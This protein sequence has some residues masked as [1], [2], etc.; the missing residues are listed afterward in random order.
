MSYVVTVGGNVTEI[1]AKMK[2]NLVMNE[3]VQS[4]I[5]ILCGSDI[6]EGGEAEAGL[7]LHG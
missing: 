5:P 1:E 4:F 2:H 6:E 7:E 3:L